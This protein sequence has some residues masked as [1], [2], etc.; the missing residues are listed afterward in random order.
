MCVVSWL[1]AEE[2][3]MAVKI[4]WQPPVVPEERNRAQW[5]NI[6][7]LQLG[8]APEGF[9]VSLRYEEDRLRWRLDAA[10]PKPQGAAI[11]APYRAWLVHAL[12]AA[13]KPVE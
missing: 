10:C 3:I 7:R 8:E 12:R 1:F 9:D 11:V 4:V 6:I 13:G 5:E 2:P